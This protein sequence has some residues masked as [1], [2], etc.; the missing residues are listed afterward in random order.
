MSTLLKFCCLWCNSQEKETHA[1]DLDESFATQP[2]IATHWFSESGVIDLFLLLGP[3]ISS[4][5]YEYRQLTGSTPLP[6]V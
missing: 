5:F 2:Q 4:V 1:A 3:N 6:P